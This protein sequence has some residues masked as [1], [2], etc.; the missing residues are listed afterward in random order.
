MG[1][2]CVS[3]FNTL[4]KKKNNTS[5]HLT[6]KHDMNWIE[7]K[8]VEINEREKYFIPKGQ[9]WCGINYHQFLFFLYDFR[10]ENEFKNV[11]GKKREIYIYLLINM[12]PLRLSM[13]R[14]NYTRNT[15]NIRVTHKNHSLKMTIKIYV[16]L[17]SW[18]LFAFET[19]KMKN[20]WR[21]KFSSLK[22]L[23]ANNRKFENKVKDNKNINKKKIY[24]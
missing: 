10:C 1:N 24:K 22:S 5:I 4:R 23:Q 6:Q 19:L 15:Q 21:R 17:K 9:N 12:L 13:I 3:I 18:K 16:K 20:V 2:G 7:R 8:S 11:K 14:I